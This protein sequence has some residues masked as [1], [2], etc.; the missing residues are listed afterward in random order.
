[1]PKIINDFWNAFDKNL[2]KIIKAGGQ[3][4][5]KLGKGIIDSIPLIIANAGE[6]V[7]ARTAFGWRHL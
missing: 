4:I 2:W 5:V 1:M 6:I 7:K 3:L